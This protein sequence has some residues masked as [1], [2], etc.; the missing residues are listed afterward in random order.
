[1][2]SIHNLSE[3]A[4]LGTNIPSPPQNTQ[5]PSV[6]FRI[7]VSSLSFLLYFTS[8]FHTAADSI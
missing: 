7:I 8:E 4:N 5:K 6:I 2:P 1:M 3:F